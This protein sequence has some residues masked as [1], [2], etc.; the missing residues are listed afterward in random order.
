MPR[1]IS[2]GGLAV[3]GVLVGFGLAA[4]VAC[5]S[6]P[7]AAAEGDASV[8]GLPA[9]DAGDSGP[10]DPCLHA[11]PP[12]PPEVDDA[13]SEELAPIVVALTER[14]LA[15]KALDGFDLDGVCTCDARPGTFGRGADSCLRPSGATSQ[16]DLD[17]GRDNAALDLFA[18]FAS[19]L[20]V[21]SLAQRSI[22]EGRSNVLFAISRYNGRLND[23][24][25]L[26]AAIRSNGLLDAR[27]PTSVRVGQTKRFTPGW[28][29]DDAWTVAPDALLGGSGLPAVTGR[30]YVRNGVLVVSFESAVSIPLDDGTGFVIEAPFAAAALLPLDEQM[31]P[32]D[33]SRPPVGREARLWAL[34]DGVLAGRLGV[35]SLVGAIGSTGIA[36][37]DGGLDPFCKEPT[38]PAV[39]SLLCGAVDIARAPSLDFD[40]GARCDAL[41]VGLPID[42][43][44]A[45]SG[46]IYA[47]DVTRGPCSAG[48]DGDP[49]DAPGVTYGCP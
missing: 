42:A 43:L 47:P 29:G 32:R 27:C 14:A 26:V 7:F 49:V 19:F 9:T 23:K 36:R 35:R 40:P 46:D 24:D 38:F 15:V 31:V 39:R 37:A 4:G 10:A 6:R 1:P 21:S 13:P 16:C 33:R 48:P 11:R 45:V 12:P 30:G 2:R 3:T 18:R 22:S 17:G 20:D 25:V 41:S 28:C 44:P 34:R 8:D 5:A